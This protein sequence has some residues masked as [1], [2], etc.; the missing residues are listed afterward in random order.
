MKETK[1]LGVIV[2]VQGDIAQVGM[3]NMSNDAELVWYG[4]IY[5]SPENRGIYNN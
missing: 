2:S 1:K 4:D 5:N 3:Y